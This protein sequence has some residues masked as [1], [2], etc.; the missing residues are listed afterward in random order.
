MGHDAKSPVASSH[1][2]SGFQTHTLSCVVGIAT[3]VAP[4]TFC[5]F[6]IFLPTPG[7]ISSSLTQISYLRSPLETDIVSSLRLKPGCP[8][9][10][11]EPP[12]VSGSWCAVWIELGP[13]RCSEPSL[14]HSTCPGNAGCDY[15]YYPRPLPFLIMYIQSIACDSPF[16][17]AGWLKAP[18]PTSLQLTRAPPIHSA[19]K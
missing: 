17:Q 18:C 4:H 16:S 6:N 10:I 11:M 15:G 3:W 1:F 9:S 7:P 8:T 19:L 13:A 5:V 2:F 14:V 12:C